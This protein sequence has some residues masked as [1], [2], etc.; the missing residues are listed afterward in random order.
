MTLQDLGNIAQAVGAATVVGGAIFAL[1]QF[2]EYKRQRQEAVAA[3][4]MRTFIGAELARALTI[5]RGMPDAVSAERLRDEGF[6]AEYAAVL[7]CTTFETLGVLVF[8]RIA[9]FPLVVELAGGIIVVMWRKLGPWLIQIREE[10]KQPS[11][12]EWFEWLARQCEQW[13]DEDRPAY[14]K[15]ADWKPRR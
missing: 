12:A 6:E 7:V 9:P 8:R 14:I 5:L 2:L 11:W 10:Q 1:I 4:V 3:E 13:K 15:H